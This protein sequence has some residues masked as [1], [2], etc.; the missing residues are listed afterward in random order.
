MPLTRS[1]QEVVLAV[2]FAEALPLN[3]T[4]LADWISEY[5]GPDPSYQQ[6]PA[7]GPSNLPIPGPM[8]VPE[9]VP[10]D[11]ADLPRVRLRGRDSH[12]L[13]IFQKDR[14]G[15]GWQR[16]IEV[17]AEADYPGYDALR[18]IWLKEIDRFGAWLEKELSAPLVPRFVELSYNNAYPLDVDSGR[19]RMSDIFRFIDVGYR[20]VNALQVNWAEYVGGPEQGFVNAQAGLGSAAPGLR[21]FALNYFGLAAVEPGS[22]SSLAEAIMQGADKLH[23]RI[24]DMHR[25]AIISEG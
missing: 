5:G 20:P 21:V 4:D 14:I 17:G 13:Y 6:L 8:M 19:R 23:E 24:L 15:F 3:L 25:S 9:L 11:G 16:D 10:V 18:G 2:H 1:L 22:G 7:L 12:T